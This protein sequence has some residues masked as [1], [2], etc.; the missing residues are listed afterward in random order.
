VYRFGID[1]P[2]SNSVMPLSGKVESTHRRQGGARAT[3]DRK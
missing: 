3:P 1:G 2:A